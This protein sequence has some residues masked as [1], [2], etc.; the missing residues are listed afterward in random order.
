MSADQTLPGI[1][2]GAMFDGVS[3]C[4]VSTTGGYVK[5]EFMREGL[6]A[7]QVLLTPTAARMLLEH[8]EIAARLASRSHLEVDVRRVAE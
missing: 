5:I 7:Q 2:V 4:Q 3:G 8:L 1:P 6:H